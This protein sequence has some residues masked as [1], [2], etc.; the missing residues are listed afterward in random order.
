MEALM[1]VAETELERRILKPKLATPESVAGYGY[2]IGGS[3]TKSSDTPGYYGAAVQTSKPAPF[4]SNDDTSLSLATIN[5][6]PM[7]VRWME[8]HNKHTQTF[9]PL[10]GKPMI[11][12]LGK[13]TCR[14]PDGSWDDSQ[15]QTPN[16]DSVEAFYFDGAAGFVMNIGTWHEF[17]FAVEPDSNVVVILTNETTANLQNVVDGEAHGDDLCKRDLQKRFGV[18]FEVEV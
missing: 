18:V 4:V 6:R 1:A 8:Y 12:V 17:P 11:A 14:R 7:E 10:E 15:E 16:I 13:P 5:P 9:I 3:K 2:L